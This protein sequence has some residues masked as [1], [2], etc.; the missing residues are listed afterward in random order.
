MEQIY[1]ILED[2]PFLRQGDVI[3]VADSKASWETMINKYYG[4]DVISTAKV[5]DVRDSGIEYIYTFY[6]DGVEVEITIE[7][8]QLNQI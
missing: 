8:Y 1:V 6:D 2:D 5:E 3:G 4:K 7:N